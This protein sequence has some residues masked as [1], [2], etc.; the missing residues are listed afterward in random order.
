M[1]E[2]QA[3]KM[4]REN[5]VV[6]QKKPVNKNN[7]LFNIIATAA[8]VVVAALAAVGIWNVVTDVPTFGEALA[9]QGTTYDIAVADW[10]LNP[11]VFSEDMPAT[12]VDMLFTI[13]NIAKMNGMEVATLITDMGLPADVD[14]Q[15]P[16]KELPTSVMLKLQTQYLPATVETLRAYGLSADIT[17]ETAWGDAYKAVTKAYE[18]YTEE[19]AAQLQAEQQAAPA[20][21]AA[22][23]EDAAPAEDADSA[24]VAE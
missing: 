5:P 10:G 16:A 24:E 3:K 15:K 13:E 21:D 22:V 14:T 2:R 18:K 17:E 6:E 19:Y 1:S 12:E 7:R 4:R 20:E 8:I 11:E 23:A 9:E